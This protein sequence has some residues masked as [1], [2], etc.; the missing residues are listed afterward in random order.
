MCRVEMVWL[1]DQGMR[2]EQGA[3]QGR[4]NA[5]HLLG[6]GEAECLGAANGS[7]DTEETLIFTG[8]A[9]CSGASGRLS[10]GIRCIGG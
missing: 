1:V 6:R 3:G 8:S 10:A 4:R 5:Q 2:R 7:V 9:C